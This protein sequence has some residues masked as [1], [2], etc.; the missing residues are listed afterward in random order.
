MINFEANAAQV[1]L[2]EQYIKNTM[3]PINPIKVVGPKEERFKAMSVHFTSGRFGLAAER[4]DFGDLEPIAALEPLVYEWVTF[5][6]GEHD[7]I[8]DAVEKAVIAAAYG[9]EAG[10]I[11][12]NP[13]S[14]SAKEKQKA[15]LLDATSQCDACKEET[16][17]L[18]PIGGNMLCATCYITLQRNTGGSDHDRIR[19]GMGMPSHRNMF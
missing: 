8:L 9:V 10:E 3:L 5:P 4:N 15:Y 14:K 12:I 6:N 13:G 2:A 18:H 16:E 1:F 7:D 11:S 17:L 19:S